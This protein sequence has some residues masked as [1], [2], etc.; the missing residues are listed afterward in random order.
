MKQVYESIKQTFLNQLENTKKLIE[1]AD[2]KTEAIRVDDIN[3]IM[4]LTN[5]EE[6]CARTMIML[7]KDRDAIIKKLEKEMN[8]KIEDLSTLLRSVSDMASVDISMIAEELRHSLETLKVKND[9]NNSLMSLILEQIEIANNLIRGDRV[10]ATYGNT[11]FTK[12]GYGNPKVD[13]AYFDSKY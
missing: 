4:Q 1:I 10:P 8:T 11:K 3:L 6:E 7:E 5:K 9:I 2:L 13:V 12:K